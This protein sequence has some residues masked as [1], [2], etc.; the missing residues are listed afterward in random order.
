[1]GAGKTTVGT[2][3]AESLGR[4][5]IDADRMIEKKTGLTIPDIFQ[6]KGEAAFRVFES[7]VIDEVS[8]QTGLVVALGGGAIVN[9][10]NREKLMATGIVI[11]LKWPLETLLKRINGSDRPL[12]PHASSLF[13]KRVPLYEQAHLIIEGE[14]LCSEKIA[15]KIKEAVLWN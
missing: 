7:N 4:S 1:M 2:L 10:K 6:N 13:E 9:E 15:E 11:Y 3:L 12:V 14:N 8:A 5:F